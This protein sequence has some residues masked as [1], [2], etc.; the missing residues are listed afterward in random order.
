MLSCYV[1]FERYFDV[2][3][4]NPLA[5]TNQTKTIAAMY[6]T[7]EQEKKRMYNQRVIQVEHGTFTPLVFSTSGGVGPEADNLLKT[8]ANRLSVKRQEPY[9]QV[10]SFLRR[11]VRFD[12][13]RTS[14]I[15]LRGYRNPSRTQCHSVK[16]LDLNLEKVA[17]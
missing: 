16:E 1:I 11:R 3:V 17:Y 12:L 10:V 15:S 14:V 8:L 13:L 6:R 2:R 9:S 7:H 4:F 5:K